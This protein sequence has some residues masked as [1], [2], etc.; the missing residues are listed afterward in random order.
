MT[1]ENFISSFSIYKLK[2]KV[3]KSEEASLL[4]TASFL[5][6]TQ[7]FSMPFAW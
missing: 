3:K 2:G 1:S 4:E 5:T 7:G 6:G